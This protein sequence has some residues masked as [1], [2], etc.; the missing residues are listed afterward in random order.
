MLDF[1]TFMTSDSDLKLL[2]YLGSQQLL[3]SFEMILGRTSNQNP[4]HI[5]LPDSSENCLTYCN[6]IPIISQKSIILGHN[7]TLINIQMSAARD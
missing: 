7:T 6:V 4:T 1:D 3:F 2:L 5:L